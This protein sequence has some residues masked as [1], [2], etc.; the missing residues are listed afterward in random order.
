MKNIKTFYIL[1]FF[2]LFFSFVFIYK[3]INNLVSQETLKTY[4]EEL[5]QKNNT[6]FE[7][8]FGSFK[9]NIN[10]K[11]HL[12]LKNIKI[13]DLKSR[14]ALSIDNLEVVIS[15]FS[16]FGLGENK[17]ILKMNGINLKIN[18]IN[19][20][21]KLKLIFPKIFLIEKWQ[22]IANQINVE[23]LKHQFEFQKMLLGSNGL[24]KPYSFEFTYHHFSSI[25]DYDLDIN[26][27]FV[28]EWFDSKGQF[29]LDSEVT[30]TNEMG[31]SFSDEIRSEGSF[32]ND[33]DLFI[34][35]VSKSDKMNATG[36]IEIN[37]NSLELDISKFKVP[38]FVLSKFTKHLPLVNDEYFR[39]KLNFKRQKN[40]FSY[41]VNME[42]TNTNINI[43]YSLPKIEFS[44]SMKDQEKII[45]KNNEELMIAE[46][47]WNHLSVL[48]KMN[49]MK[50]LKERFLP[51]E[52]TIFMGDTNK[53]FILKNKNFCLE[54]SRKCLVNQFNIYFTEDSKLRLKINSV[55]MDLLKDSF[56]NFTH[57]QA[58]VETVTSEMLLEDTMVRKSYYKMNPKIKLKDLIFFHSFDFDWK[59]FGEAKIINKIYEDCDSDSCSYPDIIKIKLNNKNYDLK[60]D[61][62][63]IGQN[64]E[65]LITETSK[66]FKK[67]LISTKKDLDDTL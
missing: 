48:E 11:V 59:S 30:A 10:S 43:D 62:K 5:A 24:D 28:G 45:L 9:K 1:V 60:V 36:L 42:G 58:Q 26:N 56:F 41:L 67:V 16:F 53:S 19:E 6:K 8:S 14:D 29:V 44:Y 31:F 54:S 51:Y 22:I 20:S 2:I 38:S 61:L 17:T 15:L 66:P 52:P 65:A 13:L 12:H 21:N 34:K 33:P 35:W 64:H 50:T 46:E 63:S 57:L 25:E 40:N 3:K 18:E 7:L 27:R 32:S 39:G 55:K 37:K 4:V 23:Y 49:L 47:L